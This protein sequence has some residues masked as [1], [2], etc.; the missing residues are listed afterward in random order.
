[1][2]QILGFFIVVCFFLYIFFYGVITLGI[3]NIVKLMVI[4]GL[5]LGVFKII[6]DIL[7]FASGKRR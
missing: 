7:N 2:T 6:K 5:V 1:M 4:V 3:G